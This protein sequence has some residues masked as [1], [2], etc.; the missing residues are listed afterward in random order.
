ML[1]VRRPTVSEVLM[2]LKQ[3][4]L[5]KYTRG[6]ITVLDREGL[7]EMSCECYELIRDRYQQLK[8]SA[9]PSD[10]DQVRSPFTRK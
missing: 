2:E 4:N 9:N 7:E 10:G 6:T 8:V 1:A 3:K 5:I